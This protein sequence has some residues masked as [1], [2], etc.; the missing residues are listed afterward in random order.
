MKRSTSRRRPLHTTAV[1]ACTVLALQ[2]GTVSL[3]R[4]QDAASEGEAEA[5]THTAFSCDPARYE[6]DSFFAKVRLNGDGIASMHLLRT[7]DGKEVGTSYPYGSARAIVTEDTRELCMR[8][9]RLDR[10]VDRIERRQRLL[11]WLERGRQLLPPLPGAREDRTGAIDPAADATTTPLDGLEL[12]W[13]PSAGHTTGQCF[14]FTVD[15][16]P[17]YVGK[18]AF[19]SENTAS[20][21]AGQ[22]NVSA[23]IS[24]GFGAFKASG[25]FSYSDQ[26]QASANSGSVYF[27]S[28]LIYE[29]NTV[30]ASLSQDGVQYQNAGEFATKCGLEF[31]ST[32]PAGMLVTLEVAYGSSSEETSQKIAAKLSA[33]DLGVSLH[34]AASVKSE[35]KSTASYLDVNFYSHGGGPG[36]FKA[37][38]AAFAAADPSGSIYLADCEE[39]NADACGTFATTL[40]TDLSAAAGPLANLA[41]NVPTATDLG[42]F[43]LFPNGVAGVDATMSTIPVPGITGDDLLKPYEDQLEQF[44]AL[45][46]E[47]STLDARATR[48][49]KLLGGQ[50]GPNTYNPEQ[51][52]LYGYLESMID[53]TEGAVS[54][55]TSRAILLDDLGACLNASSTNVEE[56]CS[57]I[58]HGGG[59]LESA[60]EWYDAEHGYPA[61]TDGDA[62]AKKACW[63]LQQNTI[64]LQYAASF[65]VDTAGEWAQDVL[66]V[67]ELPPFN[68]PDNIP[69]IAGDAALVTFADR[70]FYYFDKEET[71]TN[72]SIL[73][74]TK[75]TDLSEVYSSVQPDQTSAFEW[76][77]IWLNG[78]WYAQSGDHYGRRTKWTTVTCNPTFESPCPIGFEWS[79]PASKQV[80]LLQTTN[81]IPDMF[82]P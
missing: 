35:A 44:L 49:W 62:A 57:P 25:S 50:P 32:V 82:T 9:K 19:D 43:A 13:L 71:T 67:D 72:V 66:Y 37:L 58:I 39:G 76:F 56:V 51:L 15:P 20:S 23:T 14:N 47:I 81:P 63:F 30:Y 34:A 60:Y 69:D 68:G 59:T 42:L 2:A 53:D 65:E 38:A 52:D 41:G 48:L 4:A 79:Y 22:T 24:G 3:V 40:G 7:E 54:Y 33:S 5:R 36:V 21:V 26:W 64:A 45:L 73:A 29:M 8:S 31:I 74:L 46:N 16:L 77:G 75:D 28:T 12:G 61:C 55:A 18:V 1:T 6:G 17:A 27:N 11:A 70:P 80:D 10:F 78:D